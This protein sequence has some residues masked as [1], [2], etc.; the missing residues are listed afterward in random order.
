MKNIIKYTLLFCFVTIPLIASDLNGDDHFNLGMK[1]LNGDREVEKDYKKAM[2]RFLL[3]AKE[4]HPVAQFNL[5][6]MYARGYG[7]KQDYKEA[8]KWYLLAAE[9]NH[10]EAQCSLGQMY[11]DG[12]GVPQDLNEAHKWFLSCYNFGTSVVKNIAKKKINDRF[13]KEKK[14]Y[15]RYFEN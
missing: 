6:H 12:R 8:K 14:R 10:P 15:D 9:Q 2:E 4:N 3:A 5:G 11:H 7:V 13:E 1:Y